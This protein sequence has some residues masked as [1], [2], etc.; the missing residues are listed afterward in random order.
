[1]KPQNVFAS[2]FT[3]DYNG[4]EIV[5]DLGVEDSGKINIKVAKPKALSGMTVAIFGDKV[6]VNYLGISS[7]L[8]KKDLPSGAF[9]TL[10][11]SVMGEINSNE[12]KNFKKSGDNFEANFDSEFGEINVVLDK[13]F[14][15][16]SVKIANRGFNLKL[17]NFNSA[18]MNFG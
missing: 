3:L 8:D 17:D 10:I 9:F 7:E 6:K 11:N 14:F 4:M 5:G 2:G 12:S 18:P 13:S 1:M 15:I 16:K